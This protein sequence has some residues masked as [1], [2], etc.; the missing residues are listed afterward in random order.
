MELWGES[1]NHWEDFIY[2]YIGLRVLDLS[3]AFMWDSISSKKF[4]V[5]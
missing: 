3:V 1:N 5:P 2:G 4:T